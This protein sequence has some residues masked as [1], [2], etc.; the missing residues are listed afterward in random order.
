MKHGGQGNRTPLKP[1][2]WVEWE[3]GNSRDRYPE[4]AHLAGELAL[5]VRI[6]SKNA[7]TGGKFQ[8]VRM[9]AVIFEGE[10]QE[11]EVFASC[12]TVVPIGAEYEAS[13]AHAR[14]LSL[15]EK[16]ASKAGEQ[17]DGRPHTFSDGPLRRGSAPG[18]KD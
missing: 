7:L 10:R 1:G 9:A 5:V 6:Y 2:D 14:E 17:Q 8:P 3:P 12:L 11:R 15:A 13:I 16:R 18:S 4:L